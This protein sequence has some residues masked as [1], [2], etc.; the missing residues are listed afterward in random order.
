M[1]LQPWPTGPTGPTGT[2]EHSATCICVDQ[3]RNVIQ[4]LIELYP[5]DNVIIAME[6]GNNVS[7]RLGSLLP[8]PNDNPSS[9]LLEILN[10]QGT[11][12]ETISL[13]RITAIRITSSTYNDSITY[14][15]APVP[16][17]TGCDAD[18]ENAIRTY[19]PVG[20]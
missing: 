6:C 11:P 9:G 4:Q 8:G 12:E 7:G 5:E 2:V 17:P 1:P 16:L 18:C 3:M 20:T 15:S 10:A 19:I 13:C 14:L